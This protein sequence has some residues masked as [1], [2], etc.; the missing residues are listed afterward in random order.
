MDYYKSEYNGKQVFII[1]DDSSRKILAGGEFNDAKQE[2][3][4]SLMDNIL[5]EYSDL[6]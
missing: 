6:Y 5:H 4:I 2:H 1:M 3:V